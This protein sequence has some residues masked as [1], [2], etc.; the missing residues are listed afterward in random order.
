MPKLLHV[1]ADGGSG[2]RLDLGIKPF[3]T[4]CVRMR[5]SRMLRV[6]QLVATGMILLQTSG[7]T[8][9]EF[10]VFL[11]TVF[12]GITAAGAVVIINNV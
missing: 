3:F 8:T 5:G 9:S 6:V 1:G 11:Q 7:C 4:E 10:I 2:I 12:L